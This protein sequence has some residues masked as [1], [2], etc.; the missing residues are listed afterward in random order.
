MTNLP[1]IIMSCVMTILSG[2]K[3][4]TE[5]PKPLV[6]EIA[7][8]IAENSQ[9]HRVPASLI[10]AVIRQESGFNPEA[11]SADGM[12]LGLMQVRRGGAIPAKYASYTDRALKNVRLNIAIGTSYLAQMLKRC[13]KHPLSM[14]NSNKCRSSAYSGRVLAHLWRYKE[15]RPETYLASFSSVLGNEYWSARWARKL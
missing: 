4:G 5:C 2:G 7:G 12:D 14:Y 13:P 1:D 8:T 3:V 15:T 11:V 9:K 10:A 6:L